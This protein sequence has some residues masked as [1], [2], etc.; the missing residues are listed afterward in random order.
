MLDA[1]LSTVGKSVSAATAKMPASELSCQE[2][3]ITAASK[4]EGTCVENNQTLTV[5]NGNHTLQ[6]TDFDA[7][8]IKS[9]VGS[10]IRAAYNFG[11]PLYAQGAFVGVALKLSDPGTQPLEDLDETELE[12]GGRFYSQD[13]DAT[14]DLAPPNAFPVQPGE[15][16]GTVLVFDIPRSA[17]AVALKTGELVFPED[18]PDLDIP[19]CSHVGAIRLAGS[20]G[21]SA[22]SVTVS[23]A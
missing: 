11:T 18:D 9:V 8:I 7:S 10:Y 3:G 15:T 1:I 14:M 21:A 6:A 5:V 23:P 13:D 4:T 20:P 19:D 17:A 16:S 22:A 2:R 12:V